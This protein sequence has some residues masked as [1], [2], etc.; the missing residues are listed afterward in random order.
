M[1]QYLVLDIGGSAIKFAL[2]D[3]ATIHIKGKRKTPRDSL[4]SLL[5]VIEQIVQPYAKSVAGVAISMPGRIDSD[6]GFVIHGGS[7]AYARNI[8]LADII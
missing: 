6:T 3:K 2:M 7:L 4:E 8:H 1:K 5:F